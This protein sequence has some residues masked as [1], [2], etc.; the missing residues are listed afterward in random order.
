MLIS[1]V[2]AVFFNTCCGLNK[3]EVS[4]GVKRRQSGVE[5]VH[6][7]RKQDVRCTSLKEA[8]KFAKRNNL[9]GVICESTPLVRVPSLIKNIK[10]SGLVLVTY[11]QMNADERYRSIQERYGVD[12]LM[13]HDVVHFN[14]T[15]A[16]VGF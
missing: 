7:K 2:D 4:R 14:T 5:E 9:L 1:Y 10:E 3:D 13:I 6:T 8:V 11:G 12:A 15:M 16:G